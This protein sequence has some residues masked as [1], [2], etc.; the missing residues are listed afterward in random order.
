MYF[1]NNK[2]MV[3]SSLSKLSPGEL[4]E[5]MI[6]FSEFSYFFF[7]ALIRSEPP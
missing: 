6:S 3:E 5:H 7:K 1:K 2:R 4:G